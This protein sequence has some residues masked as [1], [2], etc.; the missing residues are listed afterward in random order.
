M[1]D[2]A[3][4]IANAVADVFG[5]SNT[6]LHH[7]WCLFHV[8]KAFKGK[9]KTYLQDRWTEAFNQFRDI[10]YSRED[11]TLAFA[12]LNLRWAE[13]SPGFCE[14]VQRQWA[15][16]IHNWAIFYRTVSNFSFLRFPVTTH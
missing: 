14:Y 8:L 13:V 16:R 4:A 12:S 3:L 2:C 6:P 5:L 7:Y 10:M 1:S 15:G 11:P 9:A